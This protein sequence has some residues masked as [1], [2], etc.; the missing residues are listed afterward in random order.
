MMP[1]FIHIKN[2]SLSNKYFSNFSEQRENE[3]HLKRNTAILE[4]SLVIH[5]ADSENV[6]NS[7][8]D[9]ILPSAEG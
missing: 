9:L 7:L 8:E 2:L 3:K 4:L 1:I 6:Y 5:I